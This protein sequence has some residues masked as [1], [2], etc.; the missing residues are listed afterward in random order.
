MTIKISIQVLAMMSLC[1]S[2]SWAA[3]P[4]QARKRP[5]ILFALADDQSWL[6]VSAMGSK[7]AH[8]PAFDRVAK[9]GVLMTHAFATCPS[10]TPSRSSILTGRHI[11]QIEQG[12]VLYGTIPKKYPLC[13]HLLADAGYHVGYT[14]KGWGPGNLAA[15]GLTRNPIGMEYN[16]RQMSSVPSGIDVRDYAANFE[17][18]LNDRPED[19]PFF[20]W[21]GCTEPHRVYE[22]GVGLKSGKKLA[23]AKVPKFWPDTD[24]VRSDLLDYAYEIEWMDAHLKRMLDKISALGE[25]DNTL[26]VVTSDNGMPFPRAKVNLYDHGVRMPL[27]I[28]WPKAVP[29]ERVIDDFMSHIDL[30]PTFLE[31]ANITPPKEM[32]GR[33]LLPILTSKASGIV[34]STR[35]RAYFALERHTW[36]RPEGAT[37][38]IRGMRTRD[39]L[40]LRNY[41]PDRWPTGGPSFVSSNKTF[42]GDIDGCPTKTFMLEPDHQQR[43]ADQFA[44]CFGKR[45]AEELYDVWKD[46][47][48]VNNLADH[49]N[50]QEARK[51]LRKSLEDY[52]ETTGDPRR[53]GDG[54]WQS[55]IY[56]QTVGFGATFNR[57]LNESEREEARRRAAHKPE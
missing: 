3:E 51:R 9:E 16:E 55:Y 19:A 45:P 6:D 47:D 56:H 12:G 33:S 36:C 13:S 15:G 40:Y 29:G 41:A 35:D 1:A 23:D 46:P 39:H 50:H 7:I 43:Y 24:L 20:F 17:A 26:V 10:C 57:S 44:W 25:L 8:T 38:P 22:D 49:P 52:Q 37:Y 53:I 4:A 31:A 28:C 48:Q 42:H 27:A 14:G 30:A 11:W 5:N 32:T 21:F 2:H 34:D 18:F 54:P